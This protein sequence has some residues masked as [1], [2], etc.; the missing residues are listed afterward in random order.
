MNN[1]A[2]NSNNEV[3]AT[4]SE[5]STN[6]DAKNENEMKLSSWKMVVA[7]VFL[8]IIICV[9]IISLFIIKNYKD[10]PKGVLDLES[11]QGQTKDN[12]INSEDLML[13]LNDDV[14]KAV[15]NYILYINNSDNENLLFNDY[16]RDLPNNRKLLLGEIDDEKTLDDIKSVLMA[17]FNDDLNVK[18]EDLIIDQDD[19]K[20]ILYS[21]D[22]ENNSFLLN[23]D[24]SELSIDTFTHE[25]NIIDYEY[26]E[27]INND[28]GTISII[29]HSLFEIKSDDNVTINNLENTIPVDY[30]NMEIEE[31]KSLLKD[32]YEDKKEYYNLINY[33]FEKV[34]DNYY[35]IDVSLE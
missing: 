24:N 19:E 31:I 32:E 30:E 33:T 15:F 5:P 2:E 9:A 20:L 29:S 14:K 8:F 4:A 35:I 17:K 18:G 10:R 12:T 22:K 16:L 3:K 13:S 1:N 6:G 21:F 7:L 28:D 11:I 27:L 26:D 23:K 25:G 34:N